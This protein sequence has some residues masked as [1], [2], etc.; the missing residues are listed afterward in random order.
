[1]T[2]CWKV[3]P[4]RFSRNMVFWHK[5]FFKHFFQ[6]KA[7]TMRSQWME[8]G[9]LQLPQLSRFQHLKNLE[10]PQI[11]QESQVLLVGLRLEVRLNYSH[12][13]VFL[14][15]AAKIISKNFEEWCLIH[16]CS[17]AEQESV[18]D[19]VL[20]WIGFL[21]GI[22]N[23]PVNMHITMGKKLMQKSHSCEWS[24]RSCWSISYSMI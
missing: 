1:M 12:T 17:I 7:L 2:S 9:H 14:F 24:V 19:L 5:L 8:I 18:E 21:M 22:D 3:L 15:G 16:N 10:I 6:I 13:N 23:I 20:I 11:L 4:D